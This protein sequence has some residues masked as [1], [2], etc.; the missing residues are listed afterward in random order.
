MEKVISDIEQADNWDRVIEDKDRID[1]FDRKNIVIPHYGQIG[2][3]F[4][5]NN[6]KEGILHRS[7]DLQGDRILLSITPI[8]IELKDLVEM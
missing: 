8:D 7:P 1:S 3:F 5:D 4:L 2:Y 6:L